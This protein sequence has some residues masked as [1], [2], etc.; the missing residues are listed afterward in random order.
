MRAAACAL[1]ALVPFALAARGGSQ[2]VRLNG[3]ALLARAAKLDRMPRS[4]AVP[5]TFDVHLKR[6]IPLRFKAAGTA[7][8]Q[9]PH[10]QALAITSLP[11]IVGRLF[12]RSYGQLD[13]IPQAWP[14]EYDVFSATADGTP[15]TYHL[16]A[17]PKYQ[18]DITHVT[19]DL[20]ANGFEPVA[21]EWFY[22]DGSTIKLAFS[23]K[24]VGAYLLPQHEDIS[25]AMRSFTVDASAEPGPYALNVPIDAGVF[26][27]P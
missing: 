3:N 16:D 13:T 25:I 10:H 27:A 17:R 2:G 14:A 18:G 7:Y 9:A 12:S 11:R 5:I 26:S 4:Y 6:P 20:R 19:F 23:Q 1:V 15:A 22:R 24:R 21:V 8:F